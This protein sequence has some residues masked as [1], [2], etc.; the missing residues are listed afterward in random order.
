MA[1]PQSATAGDEDKYWTR[2]AY[3]LIT[4]E[5]VPCVCLEDDQQRER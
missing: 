1:A 4:I 5:C 3:S 2:L